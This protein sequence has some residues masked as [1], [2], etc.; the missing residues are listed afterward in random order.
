MT[1]SQE[2]ECIKVLEERHQNKIKNP[3]TFVEKLH[4]KKG[5][6]PA[7]LLAACQDLKGQTEL[8]GVD[9]NQEFVITGYSDDLLLCLAE[10]KKSVEKILIYL[11]ELAIAFQDK[12]EE[13][14]RKK[15]G[16]GGEEAEKE[17]KSK[18]PERLDLSLVLPVRPNM[19]RWT[20]KQEKR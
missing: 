12:V 15:E 18:M 20:V 19:P 9:D 5:P 1:S 14:M 13:M 11:D 3:Q 8:A 16:A 6:S 7:A 17:G 4:N 10:E 2:E